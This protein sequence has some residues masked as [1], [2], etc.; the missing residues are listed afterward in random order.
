LALAATMMFPLAWMVLTSFMSREEVLAYPPAWWPQG[1]RL[2][3]YVEAV[4]LVPFFRF[5]LNSVIMTGGVVLL[6]LFTC[7]TAAYAFARLRFRGRDRLFAVYLATLMV[8]PIITMI[9]VFLLV[10]ELGWKGR[11][12]G[13]IIPYAGSAWG[14]FLLRQFLMTLPRDV[15]DAARLDGAGETQVFSKIILPLC[16][17]ALSVLAVFAALSTW[18]EFLWPL[19]I[20]DTMEMRPLSV[21][22]AVFATLHE[23]HPEYQMAGSVLAMLPMAVVFAVGQKFFLKG[24]VLTGA[25]K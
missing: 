4:T 20:T 13:L 25:Q 18:Q 16:K 9:P 15:E 23:R 21:G 14:V 1:L 3:N 17:P 22:L 11:Y 24:T 2:E 6:Q 10:V 8:P 19:V 5:F 7:S 12:L